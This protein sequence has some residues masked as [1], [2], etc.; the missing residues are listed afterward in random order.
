MFALKDNSMLS[1]DELA[2]CQRVFDHICNVKQLTLDMHREEI[3]KQIL[4][5]YR[6]GVKS[7]TSLIR[8]LLPTDADG[9]T[10]NLAP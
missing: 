4:M 9:G 6:D 7:E 2:V 3:A 1:P 5:A 10:P 8:L